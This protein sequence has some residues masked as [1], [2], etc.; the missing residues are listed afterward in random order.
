MRPARLYRNDIPTGRTRLKFVVLGDSN[1]G[2]TTF[3]TRYMDPYTEVFGTVSTCMCDFMVKTVDITEYGEVELQIWDTVGE[4]YRNSRDNGNDAVPSVT[5]RDAHGYILMYDLCNYDSFL[6]IRDRWLKRIETLVGNG[7]FSKGDNTE[8]DN[9]FK[10]LVVANKCELLSQRQVTREEGRTL[11]TELGLPY[12]EISARSDEAKNVGL[13][14]LMLIDR[15]MS[16]LTE[17]NS[18]ATPR[19]RRNESVPL[20]P[21]STGVQDYCC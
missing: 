4:K 3:I 2:K 12:I 7:G 15:V 6:S 10:I 17:D 18:L 5:F 16:E 13:P 1:V 9:V 19:T 14:F 8:G 21:V 20:T 11:T